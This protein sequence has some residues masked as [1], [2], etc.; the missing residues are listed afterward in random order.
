MSEV[1]SSADYRAPA[2]SPD[3]SKIAIRRRDAEGG[4]LDVWLIDPARG[5]TTRLTFDPGD[6]GNPIWSPDGTR[7][8]W[9]ANRGAESAVWVKSAS[10]A[11]S[12]EKV[13]VGQADAILDWSRDGRYILFQGFGSNLSD[14]FMVDLQGD[15][16]PHA[17]LNSPFNE[18]RGR[19]SPDGRWIAYES[20]ES[21]RS[22]V[23]VTTFPPA[24]NAGKW[25]VSTRGGIEPCW[26]RDGKELF[27]LTIDG[28]FMAVP[29]T[30]GDSFNPGTPQQLFRVSVEPGRRRN[31]YCPSPDGRKFLFL[32]A[33]G[34]NST[35]ITVMVNWRGEAGR[36]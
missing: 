3:G 17:I 29:V 21:G 16:K 11:G 33:Y 30:T 10:G 34:D 5:T 12:E 13:A 24:S 19:L 31:V 28:R 1:A 8:A 35:P 27:Y 36:K 22:E 2:L 23:Y 15:R 26:S 18:Q 4:N 6:D 9:S 14:I 7:I 20:N 25:Q 32:V